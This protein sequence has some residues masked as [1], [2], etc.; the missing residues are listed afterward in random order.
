MHLSK[1]LVQWLLTH[2]STDTA[3]EHQHAVRF[4]PG[5]AAATDGHRLARLQWVKY[6]DETTAEI[7]VPYGA[8]KCAA[9]SMS[10]KSVLNVH[11]HKIVIANEQSTNMALS[12]HPFRAGESFSPVDTYFREA[13]PVASQ[14]CVEGRY[15]ADA[16]KIGEIL[17]AGVRLTITGELDPIYVHAEGRGYT[18]TVVVMPR[19]EK[20]AASKKG[21]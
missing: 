21:K 7:I 14:V 11:P 16:V 4:R 3:R 10:T 18:A 1:K 20:P 17:G 5:E 6:P 19:N 9:A 8:L 12:E 15:L 2:A 13:V